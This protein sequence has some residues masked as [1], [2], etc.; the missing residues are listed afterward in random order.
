MS[1]NK[2][3]V[4]I[5]VSMLVIATTLSAAQTADITVLTKQQSLACMGSKVTIYVNTS[6]IDART[7][8]NNTQKTALKN[9]I[10]Q[11][12]RNN[13]ENAR[14]SENVTVTNDPAQA[15]TANRTVQIEPGNGNPPNKA[16]GSWTQG[17]N[18][19]RVYLGV[20]M[21][22][23][24]VNGSFKNADGTWNITRLG[25]A[26][27]HTSGHEVGHSFSVGHNHQTSTSGPG[28]TDNRS[29]MTAGENINSTT[30][31]N[32]SFLF[33]NHSKKVL[34]NNWGRGA[35]A[36][37]PDYNDQVLIANFWDQ[38]ILPNLPDE[39]GTLDAT[40]YHY[41]E[42]PGWYELG[43]LGI[44]TDNGALDG[45]PDFDFIYKSSLV[46]DSTDAEIIS[47]IKGNHD[48]TTW[49]LRGTDI[50]PFPGEW[51]RLN[52]D[53]VILEG[54][55][56]T[57]DGDM[58]ARYATLTWP[59][60]IVYVT[61]DSYSFGDESCPFN[62]FTYEYYTPVKPE[63]PTITGP[64]NGR[65]GEIY[66]YNFK[67]E[68]PDGD[69]IYYYIEWGDGTN[70]DWVGPYCSGY[71][72][73]VSHEWTQKGDYTI[74]AK[75]KDYYDLESDWGYLDVTMPKNK[76]VNHN[77]NLLQRLFERFPNA[78]PLL[79]QLLGL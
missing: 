2:K 44:D 37:A 77:F 79:R 1:M 56:E 47:F 59:D 14:G 54:W 27:G 50:S 61:F 63:A 53:D 13:F 57:P 33:D 71:K 69:Y 22:Y 62:G 8:L 74:K 78:F 18:T 58:V 7:D 51:F 46:M 76:V 52:P 55:I 68:D 21:N 32:A 48:R 19:T 26:I 10:I 45:D 29:K 38:P 35:C 20:F 25:N 4:G 65:Y 30:R 6:A 49:L 23:S 16:W 36:S 28:G 12:I 24:L 64:T 72:L 31:A 60:E 39:L 9:K 17:S 5:F 70:T 41:A 73:T 15:A 75:A 42:I 67:A 40:F 3:F 11:H 66:N 34:K 43:I